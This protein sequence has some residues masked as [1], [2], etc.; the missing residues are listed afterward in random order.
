MK[1]PNCYTC[2]WSKKVI[3]YYFFIK[4]KGSATICSAQ[5]DKEVQ[6][7]YNS[8]ECKELYK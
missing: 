7:V 8:K 4:Q 2:P 5:G 3:K 6:Q 1:I